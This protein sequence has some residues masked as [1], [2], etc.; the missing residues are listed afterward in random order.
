M[1]NYDQFFFFFLIRGALYLYRR[2][3]RIH[4]RY[5]IIMLL[6]QT[7]TVNNNKLRGFTKKKKNCCPAI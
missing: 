7:Y 1:N 5:N 6:W 2:C 3:P 4:V